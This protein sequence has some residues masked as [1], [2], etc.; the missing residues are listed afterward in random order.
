MRR[1]SITTWLLLAASIL[2]LCVTIRNLR[3]ETA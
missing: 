3:R 2:D 1:I